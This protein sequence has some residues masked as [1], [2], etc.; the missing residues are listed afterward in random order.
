MSDGVESEGWSILVFLI[1]VMKSSVCV[2]IF[3]VYD[4]DGNG[5]VIS[6]DML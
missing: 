3:R 1:Y 5:K 2:V 4:I 6:S